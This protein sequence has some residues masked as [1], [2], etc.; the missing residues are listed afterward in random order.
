MGMGS[1]F[2][3]LFGGGEKQSSSKTISSGAGGGSGG[4]R[5]PQCN[6]ALDRVRDRFGKAE[7][8]PVMDFL[9]I[10]QVRLRCPKCRGVMDVTG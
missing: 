4:L 1:F 9:G 3:R 7:H 2:R 6:A 5:C 10:S 8:E